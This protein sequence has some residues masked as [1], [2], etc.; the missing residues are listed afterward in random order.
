[1]LLNNRHFIP[2][3]ECKFVLR[4]SSIESSVMFVSGNL[5]VNGVSGQMM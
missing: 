5:R 1:M 2:R 4:L 3:S